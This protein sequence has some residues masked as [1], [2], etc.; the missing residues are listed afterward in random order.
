MTY[1]ACHADEG[2]KCKKIQ[3]DILEAMGVIEGRLADMLFDKLDLFN[4]AYS[5]GVRIVVASPD[6]VNTY[7]GRTREIG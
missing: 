6:E 5:P 4:L 1:E 3:A 2:D 7:R